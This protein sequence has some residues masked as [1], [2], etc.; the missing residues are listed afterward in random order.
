MPSPQWKFREKQR[1]EIH[2]NPVITEFL[3]NKTLQIGSFAKLRKTPWTRLMTG[4]RGLCF[5]S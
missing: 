5:P 4:R 2:Q 3:R 1:N